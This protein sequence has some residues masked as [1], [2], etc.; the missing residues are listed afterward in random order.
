M[1]NYM[2][3]LPEEFQK[4]V[5]DVLM[6]EER[7]SLHNWEAQQIIVK[8][9][10]Q[11]IA[12][13]VSETILTTRWYLVNGIIEDL[14]NSIQTDPEADNAET[15]SLAMDYYRLVNSFSKKLGRVMSRYN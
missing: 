10:E 7:E 8:Q 12:Q 2:A 3:R 9:K 11:T 13:Y 5:T 14:K 1:E 15:L 6:Q 4:E